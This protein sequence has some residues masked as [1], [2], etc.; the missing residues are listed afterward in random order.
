MTFV[1]RRECRCWLRARRHLAPRSS[2][3]GVLMAQQS[4]PW[5]QGT[6][7][8][9]TRM[10]TSGRAFDPIDEPSPPAAPRPAR[11]TPGAPGARVRRDDLPCRAGADP[12]R[13]VAFTGRARLRSAGSHMHRWAFGTPMSTWSTCLPQP[14]KVNFRHDGQTARWHTITSLVL[15]LRSTIFTPSPQGTP[16]FTTPSEAASLRRSGPSS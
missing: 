5:A 13:V 2:E 10:I 14:S 12:V 4:T 9:H 6:E 8:K 11:W 16:E 3:I 15:R 1:A 7:S